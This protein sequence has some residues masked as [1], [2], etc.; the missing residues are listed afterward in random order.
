M[1]MALIK[2]IGNFILLYFLQSLSSSVELIPHQ[3][4]VFDNAKILK[5]TTKTP[6]KVYLEVT[7]STDIKNNDDSLPNA[8]FP[9]ISH[10][11]FKQYIP[12]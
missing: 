5:F 11:V 8:I 10:E 3:V 9:M 2:F 4:C 12:I 7:N 6:V 1:K